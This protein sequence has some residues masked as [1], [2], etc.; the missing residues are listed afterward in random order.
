MLSQCYLKTAH[1]N[2]IMKYIIDKKLRNLVIRLAREHSSMLYF[3]LE[4]ND[5][6]AFYSTLPFKKNALHREITLH[7][8]PELSG[9]LD[10]ILDHFGKNY[11]LEILRDE[12]VIDSL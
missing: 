9:Q 5:N 12:L 1:G 11:P 3:V 10:N 6:V 7:C 8:T 2:I 4:S